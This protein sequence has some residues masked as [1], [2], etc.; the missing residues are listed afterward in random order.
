MIQA[1]ISPI[2]APEIENLVDQDSKKTSL[3]KKSS[4]AKKKKKTV[5]KRKASTNQDE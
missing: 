3:I 1:E 5:K 4:L 2:I